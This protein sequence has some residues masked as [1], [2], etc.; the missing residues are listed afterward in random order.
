MRASLGSNHAA[1][2]R[3]ADGALL[4]V[5]LPGVLLVVK[6]LLISTPGFVLHVSQ[7]ANPAGHFKLQLLVVNLKISQLYSYMESLGGCLYYLDLSSSSLVFEIFSRSN[8]GLHTPVQLPALNFL[9]SSTRLVA[10]V[11]QRPDLRLRVPV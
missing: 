8:P 6:Y 2:A 11:I 4:A 5:H 3:P 1:G 9:V 7:G 10:V